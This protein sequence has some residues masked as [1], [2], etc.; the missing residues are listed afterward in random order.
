MA[1]RLSILFEQIE[2]A[3]AR[4]GRKLTEYQ[5][6]PAVDLPDIPEAA[7][8]PVY[9]AA[10]LAGGA[11]YKNADYRR[12]NPLE[13]FKICPPENVFILVFNCGRRFLVNREGYSYARYIARLI[14]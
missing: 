5:N 10:D 8:L 11:V 13:S 2:A 12:A 9:F 4:F 7:F 6:A 1:A 14:G 3:G